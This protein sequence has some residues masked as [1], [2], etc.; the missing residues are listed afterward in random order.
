MN[1]QHILAEIQRIALDSGGQAPGMQGFERTTGIKKSDWY[2]HLWLRW[3]DALVEAG[4]APNIFQT[5]ASDEF[6]IEKYIG[7]VRELGRVPL[8]GGIRRKARSD[9]SCPSHSAFYRFGG[10]QK[11]LAVLAA[12]CRKDR[13]TKTSLL[14]A[15]SKEMLRRRRR[16]KCD[17]RL[18]LRLGSFIS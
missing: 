8:D 10:K 11:L 9:A 15:S 16:R 12:H 2:P 13:L 1:R 17:G 18:R 5:R 4:Y 6:F 7:F 3:G 14:S